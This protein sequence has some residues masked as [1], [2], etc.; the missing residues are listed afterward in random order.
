MATNNLIKNRLFR[1]RT[2]GKVIARLPFVRCVVLNGSLASGGHKE[3]SDID[4]LIIAKAGR[5]FSAR[6]FVNAFAS[7]FRIKRSKNDSVGHAGKFCFNYF[8]TQDFLVIPTGRGENMDRYCAKNY[9]TSQFIAGD[10]KLYEKFMNTNRSLFERFNCHPVLPQ[11]HPRL[12]RGSKK[13][14]YRFRISSLQSGITRG[15]LGMMQ[16]CGDQFESWAKSYQIKKIESDPR[17]K[18]YP[19]LIVYN[20]R[21]LRF[22][23]P[24]SEIRS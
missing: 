19:N 23:P 24:K 1:T 9:S 17:T 11:C 4:I 8:L 7:I 2:I 5:I 6:L 12:D 20:D 14:L 21:E 18:K 13:L 3:S 15:A 10:V 16:L 22:H